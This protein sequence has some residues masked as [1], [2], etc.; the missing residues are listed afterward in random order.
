MKALGITKT[1]FLEPVK[2]IYL[3]SQVDKSQRITYLYVIVSIARR[4]AVDMT[5]WLL[6][7]ASETFKRQDIVE[8]E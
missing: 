2:D 8:F 3:K 6:D 5:C 4:E 1:L 7:E